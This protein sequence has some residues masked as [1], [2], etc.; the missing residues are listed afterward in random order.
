MQCLHSR[1]SWR[2][3]HRRIG[4]IEMPKEGVHFSTVAFEKLFRM[5][6]L[7]PARLDG[8][9]WPHSYTV[10]FGRQFD[11]ALLHQRVWMA[12][13]GAHAYTVAFGRQFVAHQ[14]HQRVWYAD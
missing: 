5:R 3:Q 7:T 12:V 1:E 13:Y 14:L 6:T 9:L 2:S 4:A 11:R 8:C 10:A